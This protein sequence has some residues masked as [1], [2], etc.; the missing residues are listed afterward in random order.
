MQKRKCEFCHEIFNSVTSLNKLIKCI[1]KSNSSKIADFGPTNENFFIPYLPT[2]E[3]KNYPNGKELI[4]I[5]K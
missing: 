5:M 1:H 3:L 2:D 4:F